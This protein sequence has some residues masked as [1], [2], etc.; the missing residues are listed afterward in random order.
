MEGAKRVSKEHVTYSFDQA[1]EIISALEVLNR[2]YELKREQE[3]IEYTES[4][5]WGKVPKPQRYKYT[6]TER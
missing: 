4:K 5:H 6:I 1:K 3:P 2:D